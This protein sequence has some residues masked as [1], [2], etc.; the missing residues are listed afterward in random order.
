MPEGRRATLA[1]RCNPCASLT[2]TA[3]S[4]FVTEDPPSNSVVM[5]NAAPQPLP[6]AGARYERTL[7]AVGCRRL[8]LIEAPSSAYHR[9]ML[10]VG[11][12][13]EERRRPHA[14]VHPTAPS[15]LWHRLAR[16]HDVPLYLKPAWRDPGASPYARWASPLSHG[17]YAL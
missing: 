4:A 6:E 15:L 12:T 10:V 8:I 2:T 16:S 11:R 17:H 7:E 1:T 14:I 13:N 3:C 5:P 9:G